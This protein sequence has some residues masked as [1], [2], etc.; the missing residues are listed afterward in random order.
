M[1][2]CSFLDRIELKSRQIDITCG[3]LFKNDKR[4][5]LRLYRKVILTRIISRM[6]DI[7]YSLY[8]IFK[9]KVGPMPL[10][11]V[12]DAITLSGLTGTKLKCDVIGKYYPFWWKITSGGKRSNYQYPTAIIELNAG[13]G[14]VYIEETSETVLGSGGHALELKANTPN[15]ERL[16]VILIEE[17]QEC[18]ERLKRV[19]RRRWPDVH[20]SEIKGSSVQSESSNIYLINKTLDEA[21]KLIENLELGNAL[22]FFDPLRSV[23]YTTIDQVASKRLS[24]PFKTRTEF[25]IFLFT[26]DWFLGRDNFTPLPCSNIERNWSKGKKASVLEAD[27][28]FGNRKW[29]PYILNNNT[30]VEKKRALVELYR[31]RLHKWFRYVLPLPFNPKDDQ[32][33]HLILCSNYED[34]IRATRN[35]YASMTGNPKYSPNNKNALVRF[36][37]RHHSIFKNIKGRK[38]P[39]QWLFLWKIITQHEEGICDCECKDFIEI[40]PET[41]K[42]EDCL[43]WLVKEGYLKQANIENAWG[44]KIEQYALDWRIVRERLGVDSPPSIEPVSPKDMSRLL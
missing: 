43:K 29:K 35:F 20:A 16:T 42:R 13:T 28:L 37:Y 41:T 31:C 12:R 30:I 6:T 1:I 39:L 14:E 22:Y 24:T 15:T 32:I 2:L 21:L 36:K 3:F 5:I 10:S 7:I 9:V 34:G 18:Y 44:S 8:I 26:S 23:E 38:R 40:E 17:D 19:I 4:R 25:M 33:F 27:E 11:F